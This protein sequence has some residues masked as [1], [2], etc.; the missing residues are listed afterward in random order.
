MVDATNTTVMHTAFSQF[1]PEGLG[2]SS[3]APPPFPKVS[4]SDHSLQS[5][6]QECNV[7]CGEGH[8]WSSVRDW[9]HRPV[10]PAS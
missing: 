3:L 9:W 8:A 6:R 10:I 1:V 2:V 5:L 4:A 7:G